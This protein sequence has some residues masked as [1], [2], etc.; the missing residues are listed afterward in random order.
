MF[1]YQQ[2]RQQMMAQEKYVRFY[3]IPYS[4]LYCAFSRAHIDA[5]PVHSD[6]SDDETPNGGDYTVYECPGLAPVCKFF[7]RI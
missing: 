2:Q 4:N 7:L 5:K 6:D 1:H 3:W